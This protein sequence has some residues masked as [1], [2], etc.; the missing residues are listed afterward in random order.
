MILVPLFDLKFLTEFAAGG[1][2]TSNRQHYRRGLADPGPTLLDEQVLW[3]RPSSLAV[4]MTASDS[5]MK[6]AKPDHPRPLKLATGHFC[7]RHPVL[8]ADRHFI[9]RRITA[10]DYNNRY[11]GR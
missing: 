8:S 4:M 3:M 2:G 10:C 1:V 9:N 11:R 5:G 7:S 6:S